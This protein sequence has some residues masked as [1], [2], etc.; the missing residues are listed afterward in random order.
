VWPV[1]P[2]EVDNML[3]LLVQMRSARLLPAVVFVLSR[4][5]CEDLGR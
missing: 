3:Q 2:T 5:A 1:E 4:Q